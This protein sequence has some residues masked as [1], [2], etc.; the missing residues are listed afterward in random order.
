MNEEPMR[1]ADLERELSA[2]A[3][4][5]RRIADAGPAPAVDAAVRARAA[6]RGRAR[7]WWVPATVAATAVLAISLV[8]RVA[9]QPNIAPQADRIDSPQLPAEAT[10]SGSVPAP[11]VAVARPA[12]PPQPEQTTAATPAP[13]PIAAAEAPAAPS[14]DALPP[15]PPMAREFAAAADTRASSAGVAAPPA[16]SAAPTAS[17]PT[18]AG[19]SREQWLADIAA[20]RAAGRREEADREQRAFEAAYPPEPAKTLR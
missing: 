12:A 6:G 8:V 20:L 3:A 10:K 7:R 1:D 4:V 5:H 11:A 2:L 15:P 14:A 18:A 19:R 9:E 13:A 16:V 17:L